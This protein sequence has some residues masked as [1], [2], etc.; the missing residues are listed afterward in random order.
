[1]SENEEEIEIMDDEPK[2]VVPSS[3]FKIKLII[4]CREKPL[5]LACQKF[6][7]KNKK[8]EN[9]QLCSQNLELGD[10]VISDMTDSELL[11]IER[12]TL[13]DLVASIKD[14][15]YNEQSFRL[16]HYNHPNHNILY[17]IEGDNMNKFFPEK[18]MIYSS[19]FSLSYF[20]GFS[21]FRT[22]DVDESAFVLCN[23]AYKINKET[24]KLPYYGKNTETTVD[25]EVSTEIV[26]N[27]NHSSDYTSVI[28]KKKN[29]NITPDNFGEI[30][31]LQI[32]TISNITAKVIMDEYKTLDNLM[33]RLKENPK[34][35]DGISYVNSTGQTRKV[36]KTSLKNIQ[37]YLL[38]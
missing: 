4:D 13:Q 36:S 6:I 7:Q 25:G 34:C 38:N 15:R 29:S 8:F 26:T 1:M 2:V 16:S 23:A 24:K 20:K 11:I 12:K 32:P 3:K 28:K 5:L 22:K 33:S 10:I 30:V 14:N 9:I 31:L 19:M 21:I 37:E 27:E 17:M 18:D 35:L